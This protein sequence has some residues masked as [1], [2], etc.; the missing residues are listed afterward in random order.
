[1]V[2]AAGHVH[3]KVSPPHT[4][5]LREPTASGILLGSDAL[6]EAS[7]QRSE[8]QANAAALSPGEANPHQRGRGESKIQETGRLNFIGLI[9]RG[10]AWKAANLGCAMPSAPGSRER[11]RTWGGGKDALPAELRESLS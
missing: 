1:M 10:S 5:T 3:L 6:Q 9:K 11:K 2:T 8:I 7:L 4:H